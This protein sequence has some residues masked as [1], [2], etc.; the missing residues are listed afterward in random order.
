MEVV[1]IE[2]RATF[3]WVGVRRIGVGSQKLRTWSYD[4]QC[5]IAI[6]AAAAAGTM[7]RRRPPK[8]LGTPSPRHRRAR[9][10]RPGESFRSRLALGQTYSTIRPPP[11][12]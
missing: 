9:R 4:E 11:N 7:C 6:L 2:A 5:E 12:T 1:R 3:S 10:R 8:V